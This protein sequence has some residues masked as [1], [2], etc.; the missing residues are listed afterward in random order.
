MGRPPQCDCT[1]PQLV[2]AGKGFGVLDHLRRGGLPH[3]YVRVLGTCEA[4]TL[5]V[6]N[7][8][9]GTATPG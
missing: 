2:L 5:S 3:V 6:V 9:A 1:F 7:N 4:L 8:N